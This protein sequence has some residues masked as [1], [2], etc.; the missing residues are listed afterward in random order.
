M[1]P[2]WLV[3]Q[4]D[5]GA[6]IVRAAGVGAAVAEVDATD[7]AFVSAS[8]V[9]GGFVVGAGGRRCCKLSL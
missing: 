6:V 7:W 8:Y 4:L 9:Q 3:V 5:A 2:V 1:T